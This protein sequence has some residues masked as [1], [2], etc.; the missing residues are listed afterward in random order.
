[1]NPE[2]GFLQVQ[3]DKIVDPRGLEVRLRGVCLGGW[4]NM[5]NFITGY[6]GHESGMRAA[7]ADVL[8]DRAPLFFERLM[9]HFIAQEDL[10]YV[11]QLGCNVI[12]IPLNYRHLESDDQPFE[13]RSEGFARLDQVI[14]WARANQLYVILDLH[15]VQGWQSPGW[16]CD[17]PCHTSHFWGQQVFE[18]RAIKLWEEI[19][20][21]YSDDP[22]VAG[23]NVMNEP[24]AD[25]ISRLNQFYR[26]V[27]E[28]IRAIDSRHILFLEGNF[29]SQQFEQLDPPF[30][31]NT[32]YS[33]H[34]YVIPGLDAGEYP[35][36]FH[37]VWYDRAQ[38]EKEYR[39]RAAFMR[40]HFVPNWVGEFGCI[41][42]DPRLE[43]S[44]L[45]VLA[46]M[47]DIIER[48]GHHWTFWTYKD[49]GRMGLVCVH[50]ESEWMERTRR[51]RDAKTSLCIDY[52]FDRREGE[53]DRW[54]HQMVEHTHAV[55]GDLFKDRAA[56][57]D[58]LQ[59]A[60][61]EGVLS[62]MLLPAFAEQFRGMSETEIDR[63]MQS[64]DLKNCA[65]RAGLVRTISAKTS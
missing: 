41:F 6:P 60:I 37:G 58:K 59:T 24:V 30:D 1:M 65:P 33:S 3:G 18:E 32:A 47:L 40:R 38:L 26:R 48:Q 50:P 61:Y 13:Y 8:G 35:G 29:Y 9:D 28:A 51:V 42:G 16:H 19:A 39:E 22:I 31:G 56:M 45:R 52:W 2:P 5:E 17:T 11:R 7:I 55:A 23:Y 49:I 64:F 21:R 36:E 43:E 25:R 63:M 15:A 12:R 46:D 53:L 44:R 27:T 14:G 4:M 57:M 34:N 10:A 54:M 62:Q 20:R